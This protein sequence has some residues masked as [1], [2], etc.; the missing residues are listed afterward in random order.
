MTTTMCAATAETYLGS[1]YIS[2]SD[3][4]RVC[5]FMVCRDTG[6]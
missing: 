4:S 3:L 5:K 1:L 2:N 6:H